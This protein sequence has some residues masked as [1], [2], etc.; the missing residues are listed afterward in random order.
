MKGESMAHEIKE[1][2]HMAYARRTALD[3][4][5]HG[6]GSPVSPD[7]SVERMAIEAK[8]EWEVMKTPVLFHRGNKLYRDNKH[9]VIY[10]EEPGAAGGMVLDIVGPDWIPAQNIEILEFFR[11]YVEAGEMNLETAGSLQNGKIVWAL[12]KMNDSFKLGGMDE[13]MGYVLLSNPHQYG[14]GMVV[15]F[16]PIRVVCWNTLTMALHSGGGLKLWHNRKFDRE[17]QNEAK[18]RL[19]IARER[20]DSFQADAQKLVEMVIEESAA[21]AVLNSIF[22]PKTA[23]EQNE[24]E[25]TDQSPT[26]QKVMKL[27]MGGGHGSWLSTSRNTGW[28]LLN[29]VTQYFDHEYGKTRD[30]RMTNSWMGQ[31]EVKKR[32]TME[33]LLEMAG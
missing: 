29:A 27:Y 6:L 18:L 25:L 17:A 23:D 21:I 4:P 31:G 12:A 33:H 10:R 2:D 14:K 26:V 20:L 15:K 7:V 1:H 11:E 30:S 5:W 13:V 3:V 32:Q 8:L 19:G 24:K 16:T 22:S 28:G 9:N